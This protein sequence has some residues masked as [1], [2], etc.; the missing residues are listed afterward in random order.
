MI[1]YKCDYCGA[2]A[3]VEYATVKDPQTAFKVQLLKAPLGWCCAQT[4]RTIFETCG[5]KCFRALVDNSDIT[6]HERS[7]LMRLL[8]LD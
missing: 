6:D 7:L 3:P 5:S 8:T 2:E 4:Q 1:T